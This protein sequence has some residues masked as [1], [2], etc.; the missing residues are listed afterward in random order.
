ADPAG[1]VE[2][3]PPRDLGQGRKRPM[4]SHT[5]LS[6]DQR[7]ARALE[8]GTQPDATV[9]DQP[10]YLTE[11]VVYVRKFFPSLAPPILRA[12]AALNGLQPPPAQDFDYCELGSGMG[13]T[14]ATLAAA[15]PEARFVG[16]DLSPKQTACANGLAQRG[17]LTN[18]R[19]IE[20]DFEALI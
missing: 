10:E 8:S 12:A 6:T 2:R 3:S 9:T 4:E 16:I 5:D 20:E 14:T 1:T 17:A 19:F 7:S 15:Y 18:V 13:D 11:D